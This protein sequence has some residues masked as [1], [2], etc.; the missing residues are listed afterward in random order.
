M[1]R[2]GLNGVFCYG[3]AGAQAAN[4]TSNVDD[5]TLNM[6]KRTAEAVRRGRIWVAKKPVVSEATLEFKVWD[7][8]GDAF[9]AAI[10]AAFMNDS[11]IALWPR[12]DAAGQGLDADF[13]ITNF[14]RSEDSE[15]FITYAV[16]AEPTDE[17]RV[18]VWA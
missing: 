7:I 17:L 16:T 5:V 2:V 3:A 9:L 4:I 8:V 14:S 1:Y 18:P 10:Q 15:E 11:P 6:S 12:D 13:Y